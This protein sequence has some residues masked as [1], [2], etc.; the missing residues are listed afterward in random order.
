MLCKLCLCIFSHGCMYISKNV[1][2][3][4]CAPSRH[5]RNCVCDPIL[6]KICTVRETVNTFGYAK[7]YDD[8]STVAAIALLEKAILQYFVPF[9]HKILVQIVDQLAT[10]DSCV[11]LIKSVKVYLFIPCLPSRVNFKCKCYAHE[12]SPKSPLS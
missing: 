11:L 6:T 1:K 12:V 2:K 10:D 9:S 5:K 4:Y 3:Y 7:C 8:I